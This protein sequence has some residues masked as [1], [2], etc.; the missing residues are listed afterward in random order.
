MR[1]RPFPPPLLTLAGVMRFLQTEWHSH[2]RA[3][4]SW[5]I[6][7]EEM[8]KRI[9]SLEGEA[10]SSKGL[11]G[12]LERQIRMLEYALR[13]ERENVTKL[14]KGEHVDLSKNSKELARQELQHLKDQG[15]GTS[16]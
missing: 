15:K 12:V 16:G 14:K 10:R 6:E 9:A 4:N 11:R 8:K 7:R 5:E 2:E 3:R 1:A 13:K